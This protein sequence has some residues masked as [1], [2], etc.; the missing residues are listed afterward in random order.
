MSTTARPEQNDSTLIER[1]QEGDP[2]AMGIALESCRAYL[3]QVAAE[4]LERALRRKVNPSDLVQ[5]SFLVAQRNFA[6]FNGRS[7]DE[8]R[9]WL[10]GI[11][12]N[13]LH[14][15]RRRFL[16]SKRR[17][18]SR[19]IDLPR[20]SSAFD[21]AEKIDPAHSVGKQLSLL[22]D[23]EAITHAMSQLSSDYQKVVQWRNWELLS[24]E[25]IG[26][27]LGRSPGAARALWLR[28]LHQLALV[29]D[30]ANE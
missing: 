7:I 13:K 11:L 4:E 24:F 19:E 16:K 14:E 1:A 27:R 9:A 23:V 18:A 30:N 25:E 29:L 28:A 5:E 12:N 15:A 22:E 6:R 21:A 20:S 10:R 2:D 26:S 8:L 3:T 17:L